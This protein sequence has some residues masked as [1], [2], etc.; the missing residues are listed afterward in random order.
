MNDWRP[1]TAWPI[2]LSDLDLAKIGLIAQADEQARQG[3][4]SCLKALR[5]W[6]SEAWMKA[7]R[8]KFHEVTKK[9]TTSAREINSEL[10]SLIEALESER[11]ETQPLRNRYVHS[12]WGNSATPG[13]ICSYD[14]QSSVLSKPH[15]IDIALAAAVALTKAA[16]LC[17]EAVAALI[18]EGKITEG[19]VGKGM[20]FY[21]RDRWITF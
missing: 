4:L 11:I 17:V 7:Q 5:N 1:D 20:T 6:N 9:L 14:F 15:D 3:A 19:E 13:E 2:Y 21:W 16:R 12:L 18:S 8:L 10:V